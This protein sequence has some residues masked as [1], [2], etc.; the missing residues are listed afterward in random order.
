MNRTPFWPARRRMRAGAV[1]P[2]AGV[3]VTML[4]TPLGAQAG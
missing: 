2:T 3:L 4:A 1:L